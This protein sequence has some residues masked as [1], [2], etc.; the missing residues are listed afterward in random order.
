MKLIAILVISLTGALTATAQ[1]GRVNTL[2]TQ[3]GKVIPAGS[4]QRDTTTDA[5]PKITDTLIV[6]NNS[7]GL[8]EVSAVGVT[9]AGEAVTA[10]L[11]YRYA[12]A[13][14]TLTIASAANISAVAADTALSGATVAAAATAD[15]NIKVTITGK[16]SK[17]I[18]WR[19]K[20]D[21]LTN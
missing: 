10:K 16:A 14:G 6:G 18:R 3:Q 2:R 21:L 11:I 13:S 12:K 17:T 19:L 9:S 5:T 4:W 7:A 1:K 15:N 8:I 20:T